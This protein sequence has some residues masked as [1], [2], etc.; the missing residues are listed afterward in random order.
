MVELKCSLCDMTFD[1]DDIDYR[2]RTIRHD[3]WHNK[4]WVHHRNTTQGDP[5][6]E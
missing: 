2:G 1:T 5:T 6:Y 4:A 3:T